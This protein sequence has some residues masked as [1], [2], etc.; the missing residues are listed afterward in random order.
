MH[1]VT[2]TTAT[3]SERH[4]REPRPEHSSSYRNGQWWSFCRIQY[5]RAYLHVSAEGVSYYPCSDVYC[6]PEPASEPE[7]VVVQSEARRLA[8]ELRG[9]LTL[10][11]YGQM[12]MF[13]YAT[14]LKHEHGSPCV[15]APDH[16]DLVF[17]IS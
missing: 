4:R 1:R 3:A 7:T 11:S 14:T 8:N 6:G 9:W 17:V 13:P 15:R 12:W 10:H 16:D 5:D 2:T